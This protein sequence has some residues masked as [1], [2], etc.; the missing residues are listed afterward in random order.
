MTVKELI[1][2]LEKKNPDAIVETWNPYLDDRTREV[3]VSEI[4]H[5]EAIMITNCKL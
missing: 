5:P 2:I 3:H 1:N 4:V